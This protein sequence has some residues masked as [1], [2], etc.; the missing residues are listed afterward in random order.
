MSP[1]TLER[2]ANIC[3]K[4][5]MHFEIGFATFVILLLVVAYLI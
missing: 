4:Y 1:K 2:F 3:E 5:H